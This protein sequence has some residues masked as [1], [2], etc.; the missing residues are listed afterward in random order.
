MLINDDLAITSIT[1]DGGT[2]AKLSELRFKPWGELRYAGSPPP[3]TGAIPA[4]ARKGSGCMITM[5]GSDDV[6]LGLFI[7]A[8]TIVPEAHPG[9][10]GLE[11]L[12]RDEQQSC[13]V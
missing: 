7:Q 13:P 2:G 1:A 11:P 9:G 3:P 6:Q 10:A 4:S 8:D 12:C 5:P